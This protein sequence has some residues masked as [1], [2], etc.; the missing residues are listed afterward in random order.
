MAAN[1]N[2]P[3]REVLASN[4]KKYRQA[5]GLSQEKFAE[6]V[7]LGSSMIA[8]IENCKKFPSSESLNNICRFLNIDVYQLFL[9]NDITDKNIIAEIGNLRKSVKDDIYN[10]IDEKF[11]EFI[12]K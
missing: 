10:L 6:K 4:V 8:A 1:E 5:L 3:V 2:D 11:Q 12:T 9:P 7:S